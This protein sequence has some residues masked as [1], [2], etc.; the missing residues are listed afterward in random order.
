M[1]RI[2]E[3]L[4]KKGEVIYLDGATGTE[5]AAAGMP[6]GVCPEAW[7][8]EHE[9]VFVDL[10]KKYISAGSDI[11]YTMTFSCNEIKLSDHG[12]ADRQE[13]MIHSLVAL[14][15]RAIK[16]SDVDR[17]VL[18]FGDISM[19]GKQL[20]PVGELD[21]DELIN[22]YSR[23]VKYMLDAG[24]DGFAIET[25][26]SLAEAR[27]ALIAVKEACDLPVIVTLTYEDDG[28]T[29]FGTS[30]ET[31]MAVLQAMGAD[32]VGFNCSSGPAE[33]TEL[34]KSALKIAKVPVVVKPNAGIPRLVNG[35]TIYDLDEKGFG[36][37]MKEIRRLGVSILG[38][39]CGTTPEHIKELVNST[40]DMPADKSPEKEAP[41][42]ILTTE[43]NV[44]R[45]EKNG[46]F[47]IIGERINPTGK[48]DLKEALKTKN[49]EFVT[50]MAVSQVSLGA[51]LLDVNL[52]MNGID[53]KEIMC[54]V[55][56]K[57]TLAVDVP[58][59]IDSSDVDVIEAALRRYP[60]RALINS[61]SLEPGKAEALLPVAKKYGACVI[62][63][64]LSESGLPKDIA[65]KHKN[66]D[67][68]ISLA[69][70]AGL[71]EEDLVV[72]GLVAT[73]GANKK[74]AL[75]V[76]ETIKYCKEQKNVLTV[77][78][79]SNI[80]FGLPERSFVNTAFL[81]MAICTGLNLA[82]SNPSQT[83]L[84][85][86][87]LASDLLLNKPEADESYINGVKPVQSEAVQV[88]APSDFMADMGDIS[89]LTEAVI[90]GRSSRI[91]KLVNDMLDGGA[92]PGSIIDEQLI[93]A[94]NKVGEL[95]EK[96]IYFLPQ[97]I[98]SAESM[99]VAM[100]ILEPLIANDKSREQLETVVMATVK[101]DVHD[102]GKNLV[103]MMLKNYGY[104]VIDLGKDVETEII[105]QTA[106]EKNAAI[107]G[108]SALMTTT[109][110]EM[111]EVV[112]QKNAAGLQAKVIV[113]GACVTDD[114][115]KEIGADGYSEDAAEA[116]KVVNAL[117]GH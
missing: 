112:K 95:F 3:L 28:R 36:E 2:D 92:E 17:K 109:M 9:E 98:S 12:M 67:K 58:L 13:E 113:G 47:M 14:S 77:C 50:D 88:Q 34:I 37:A 106:K 70:E 65:E 55:T 62:L 102:I 31:A 8:M 49:I 20:K 100:D 64:P 114:Y 69:K 16:E 59:S 76:M 21:T 57:L 41:C 18:V 86:A 38:G 53:E 94:I 82:I 10:Q 90:K 27:A 54:E 45:I 25:M 35:K 105:I 15:K 97:L 96:K 74:A 68:L 99:S 56:D 115:A 44:L 22:V 66:V 107:I 40:K 26:V 75:E 104:E 32:A 60:G 83:L 6:G 48:N 81:T 73:V 42:T 93:P 80:S 78:G 30:P 71:S 23:T 52:G 72:D 46:R 79:L 85:N 91:E 110:T 7:V 116:V 1:G 43:R 11:L 117:L 4:N 103:V 51:K 87:A 19:T 63:L 89:E 111:A 5:L 39:C 61:V 24:V 84:V 29:L 101:G 33:M 108:L